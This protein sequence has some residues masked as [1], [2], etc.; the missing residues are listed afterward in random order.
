M[1]PSRVKEPKEPRISPRLG[2]NTKQPNVSNPVVPPDRVD[3]PADDSTT[4]EPDPDVAAPNRL[5][6][7]PGPSGAGDGR[8]LDT[9]T[10]GGSART[11]LTDIEDALNASEDDTSPPD[12]GKGRA[13]PD[14]SGS[15]GTQIM[16]PRL[17]TM[18]DDLQMHVAAHASQVETA[19][20]VADQAR[21][22]IQAATVAR[23]QIDSIIKSIMY[24]YGPPVIKQ[25]EEDIDLS[26]IP[27]SA[28]A[29]DDTFP[30][31]P[32]GIVVTPPSAPETTST[33]PPNGSGTP[34]ATSV[35][36]PT[37]LGHRTPEEGRRNLEKHRARMSEMI[38]KTTSVGR[39]EHRAQD[40]DYGPTE[41]DRVRE[42]IAQF[43]REVDKRVRIAEPYTSVSPYS[44]I[45]A[46][47]RVQ[48]MP[49]Q[50][51]PKSGVLGVLD[52]ADR[53]REMVL[54][55]V[56]DAVSAG[57]QIKGMK[58]TMPDAY[59]G[60]DDLITFEVWLGALLRWLRLSQAVGPQ[61]VELPNDY[62]FRKLF[63]SGL[64]ADILEIMYKHKGVVAEEGT[65]TELLAAALEAETGTRAYRQMVES[66]SCTSLRELSAPR[67]PTHDHPVKNQCPGPRVASL[68]GRAPDMVT[69][70]VAPVIAVPPVED[71]NGRQVGKDQ[72]ESTGH[73]AGDDECPKAGQP[74]VYAA[75]VIDETEDASKSLPPSTPESAEPDQVIHNAVA[76]ESASEDDDDEL[77]GVQY[78]SAEE[79]AEN[80]EISA[81]D[82]DEDDIGPPM[83]LATMR[84]AA[85]RISPASDT[86]DD[87]GEGST[88]AIP[89]PIRPATNGT[90]GV[91][92]PIGATPEA[93]WED[94]EL[95]QP[96]PEVAQAAAWGEAGPAWGDT[97]ATADPEAWPA[98]TGWPTDPTE[99]AELPRNIEYPDDTLVLRPGETSETYHYDVVPR[100]TQTR[101]D[102]LDSAY[103]DGIDVGIRMAQRAIQG[104][105]TT[106]EDTDPRMLGMD[107]APRALDVLADRP[108]RRVNTAD[109]L[110]RMPPDSTGNEG[111]EDMPPL[112]DY[113]EEHETA[114][115]SL[116]EHGID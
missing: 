42:H 7:T 56:N 36:L 19:S 48:P 29:V 90:A 43:D 65:T 57:F 70:A 95:T 63:V 1:A 80:Y 53:I 106:L 74:R 98:W 116:T 21:R 81:S 6:A 87:S 16:D 45:P 71:V 97:D 77:L 75:R 85:M 86:P 49:S 68:P 27:P 5:N 52:P 103:Q 34:E 107:Y 15:I 109:V 51:V 2:G 64:P 9:G 44:V 94:N 111:D 18:L 91:A 55:R 24:Q 73:Y 92:S 11:S 32:V 69:R 39:S 47:P 54:S 12:K 105:S 17:I 89:I 66:L 67:M 102:E 8:A 76:G 78:E 23:A 72:T 58:F 104:S 22:S 99:N 14:G 82:D 35:G 61:L 37:G 30:Y 28:P 79:Y 60:K 31:T 113:N 93:G 115:V 38:Q 26:A 3:T 100:E 112:T 40:D 10:S 13:A 84:M 59:N 4:R 62:T 114:G 41:R 88:N 50:T 101:S 25:E 83:R 108:Y 33:S 96:R 20:I 46:K 110:S